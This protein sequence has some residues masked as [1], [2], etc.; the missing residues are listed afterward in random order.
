M[1][2]GLRFAM[3]TYGITYQAMVP[4]QTSSYLLAKEIGKSCR[5]YFEGLVVVHQV[6]CCSVNDRG[7]FNLYVKFDW[8]PEPSI[9]IKMLSIACLELNGLHFQVLDPL[10]YMAYVKL[11]FEMREQDLD[12]GLRLIRENI[13]KLI[14]RVSE[15]MNVWVEDV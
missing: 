3:D 10:N 15:G 5:L 4:G 7:L 14:T 12:T 1:S 6:A 13:P 2:I 8:A 9:A 11:P